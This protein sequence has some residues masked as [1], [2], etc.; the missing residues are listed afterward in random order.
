M[1]A[2]KIIHDNIASHPILIQALKQNISWIKESFSINNYLGSS[3]YKTITGKWSD[4]Y[5]E[6]T[7]YLIPTLLNSATLLK[8]KSLNEIALNQLSFFESLQLQDGSFKVSINNDKALV[9]DTAQIVLGLIALHEYAPHATTLKLI[10]EAYCWL[11]NNIDDHGQFVKF[12]YIENYNPSYYARIVWPLLR[13]EQLLEYSVHVKTKSLYD[14]IVSL[15]KT[16][17][18]FNKCSFDGGDYFFTH[19]LIYTY[20]GLWE[21]SL[22]LH[23]IETQEYI[24]QSV[25]Y[26]L[27]NVIPK[28]GYLC[29]TYNSNWAAKGQYTCA[30]GNAQLVCLLVKIFNL[31]NEPLYF[32]NISTLMEPLIQSQRTSLSF[33]IGAIPSSVPVWGQY[34]RFK[35]TNW[36]QKFYSDALV[37]LVRA[38]YK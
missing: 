31:T 12:N 25:Q 7:G 32:K 10:K 3:K 2:Y 36:T 26:I 17:Y 15:K 4:P 20:R 30:V 21:S 27:E 8:D 19:N 6:T 16:Q 29:G 5:P 38:S 24:M 23:D 37:A 9:F 11:I 28:K 14:Y 34:Q 13:S 33:N 22:I 1:D 18:T 35:F